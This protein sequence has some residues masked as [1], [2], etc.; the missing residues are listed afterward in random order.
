MQ[1]WR[2]AQVTGIINYNMIKMWSSSNH[3]K[4]EEAKTKVFPVFLRQNGFK[5]GTIKSCT[6]QDTLY[7][8]FS[9]CDPGTR[10][11]IRHMSSTEGKKKEKWPDPQKIHGVNCP[12]VLFPDLGQN[13]DAKVES[14]KKFQGLPVIF[15][16]IFLIFL[17]GGKN[18][19]SLCGFS[20]SKRDTTFFKAGVF[21]FI[22]FRYPRK[23]IATNILTY[24][25]FSFTC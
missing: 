1:D 8:F 6:T 5:N 16:E 9:Q 13:E 14:L 3:K 11:R 17:K 7:S 15:S 25:I 18:K 2:L 22:C 21:Y 24:G 23:E 10:Y 19:W 4:V 12:A 20:F